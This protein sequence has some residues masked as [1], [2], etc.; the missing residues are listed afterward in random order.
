MRKEIVRAKNLTLEELHQLVDAIL[1]RDDLVIVKETTPDYCDIEVMTKQKAAY[2]VPCT[3]CDMTGNK[4]AKD[5][6]NKKKG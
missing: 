6:I 2:E 1:D 3:F 5:C 4:H